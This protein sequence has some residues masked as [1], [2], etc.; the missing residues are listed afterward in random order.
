MESQLLR[1]HWALHLHAGTTVQ[2]LRVPIEYKRQLNSSEFTYNI[3]SW[4]KLYV[5]M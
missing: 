4:N 5:R 1:D 3:G 2:R